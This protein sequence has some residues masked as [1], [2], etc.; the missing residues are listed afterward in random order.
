MHVLMT[1]ATNQLENAAM[2]KEAVMTTTYVLMTAVMQLKD[3]STNQRTVM[4]TTHV[5][6]TAAVLLDASTLQLFV[7][8]TMHVPL[9]AALEDLV[10]LLQL[11]SKRAITN[12]FRASVTERMVHTLEI[13]IVMTTTHVLKIVATPTLDAALI[14]ERLVTTIMHVPETAAIWSLENASTHQFLA[15]TEMHVPETAVI[16]LRDASMFQNTTSNNCNKM[17]NVTLM[18]VTAPTEI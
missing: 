18:L 6:L 10:S 11:L 16:L 17:T 7:T 1:A 12:V 4:I 5:L 2:S 3:V 8:I 14:K 9:I 15:L 13:L